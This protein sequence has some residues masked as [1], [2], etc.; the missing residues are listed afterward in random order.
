MLLP[1]ILFLLLGAPYSRAAVVCEEKSSAGSNGTH[2]CVC[3]LHTALDPS[4]VTLQTSGPW[5]GSGGTAFYDGTASAISAVHIRHGKAI[6]SFQ[7]QY[8]IGTTL[9]W[10]QPHGSSDGE[11]V[12][13][14]LNYE[15]EYVGQIKGHYGDVIL[16]CP[17]QTV[18]SI[19]FKVV[20]SKSGIART[21]GPFGNPVGTPFAS[22]MGAKIVGFYGHA[23]TAID[24]I[25]VY[26]HS[27]PNKLHCDT[28]SAS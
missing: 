11:L 15:E 21:I 23:G 13:L 18:N 12:I 4:T 26:I 24:Q 25:G 6:Y 2:E 10:S 5:G 27:A 28:V 19:E 9:H 8:V 22:P 3:P 20:N 1:L 17:C 7:T 14:N 16:P